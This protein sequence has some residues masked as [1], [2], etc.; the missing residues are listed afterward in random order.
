MSK[1]LGFALGAGGSRGVAHIGFLKAMQ[2]CGITPDYVSGTSMGS[3]V[4]SCYAKGLTPDYM[5]EIV[6]QLKFS[7]LLDL[8]INPIGNSAILRSQ[9][10]QNKLKQYLGES[11]FSELK[12]PFRCVATDLEEG[13][14]KVFG[15]DPNDVVY[16]AVA[17]SST[18][19]SVFKPVVINDVP[20]VDGGVLCR[21]PIQTVR[22][23][24]ADVI[25]AV[26]VLGSVR[27]IQKKLNVFTIAWRAFEIVDSSHTRYRVMEQK[28]DLYILP[29]LGDMSQL[30]FKDI[31][32]A[33][34]IGYQTGL[35]YADRIKKLLEE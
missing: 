10:M 15:E 5:A 1:K 25:V 23:M 27:K 32:K 21:V 2:E 8:S 16:T 33:I 9:K 34:E 17:A 35:E 28:P 4:G 31:D 3:V 7:D 13:K 26:D 12:I 20:Y 22:D 11:K 18:I 24:G 14:V 29:D 6:K 19:P 30:K